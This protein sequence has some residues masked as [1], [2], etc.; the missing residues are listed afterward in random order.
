MQ[1]DGLSLSALVAELHNTLAGGRID[2]I[3]QPDPF[4]LLLWLRCA[5]RDLPL[6]L[7]ATPSNPDLQIL[8]KAPENPASPPAFCMLLR[9]H[10][11]DGRLLSVEQQGLDRIVN[12]NISIRGDGG[13]IVSKTLVCELMG[14]H[15]NIILLQDGQ[16]IDSVKRVNFQM[17][18][19]RQVLPGRPYL[20]PPGQD[21][22]PA[23]QTDW[24]QIK[25]ALEEKNDL[26][27]HKALLQSVNGL[28]PVSIREIIWRAG[29]PLKQSIATLDA[30]DW[31]ALQEAWQELFAAL[32]A[33]SYQPTVA[34]S[35][36][37]DFMAFA[38]FKLH[39]LTDAV[40]HDFDTMSAAADF[41]RS[42]KPAPRRILLQ[43][44][45]LQQI[46]EPL[47]RARHK[48]P[49]L[50]QELQAAENCDHLR[51]CGDILMTYLHLIPTGA[52]EVD[53]PDIYSED[54]AATVKIALQPRKSNVDNAQLYYSRYNKSKRAQELLREQLEQCRQ[55]I[56]Y[57]ESVLQAAE[58]AETGAECEEI[59]QELIAQNYLKAVGKKK[60]APPQAKPLT[61]A[62]VGGASLLIGKNNRQNDLVTFKLSQTNDLWFHAKDIPG[63]HIILR[64][65]EKEANANDIR[66][67]ALLAAYFSKSRGSSNVPVDYTLRRNVK[68]PNG[69]KPGFVIYSQQ[70]TIFVTPEQQ[71][72]DAYLD[73]AK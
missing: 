66:T 25:A 73:T 44:E 32:S 33:S 31:Q 47:Q 37:G 19:Y 56:F 45:L 21:R 30:S 65:P 3:F 7:S 14:K 38:C 51:I 62:L 16:I 42:L 60:S 64:S 18:R 6:L 2:R 41:V 63:S 11:E 67:A 27:L 71:E 29:L 40:L 35:A 10:L 34:V 46:N 1:L 61:L 9:K 15:S 12:F 68:K 36:A 54:P 13:R 4:S 50:T 17:S 59:R 52:D 53:L 26:P 28:G 22:L 5:N 70:Q 55:D 72:V 20:E 24:L 69:A 39:H 23:A 58:H 48:L 8:E 49:V 57:L 43:D